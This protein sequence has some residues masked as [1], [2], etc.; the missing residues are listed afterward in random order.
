MGEVVSLVLWFGTGWR[1]ICRKHNCSVITLYSSAAFKYNGPS[2][3][4]RLSSIQRL[5]T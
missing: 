1:G 4:E 5:D 3:R 2:M